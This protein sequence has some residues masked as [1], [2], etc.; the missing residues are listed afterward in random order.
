MNAP[1]LVLPLRWAVACLAVLAATHAAAI[2]FA[3]R[4]V[5]RFESRSG[6]PFGSE[7]SVDCNR[8]MLDDEFSRVDVFPAQRVILIADKTGAPSQKRSVGDVLLHGQARSAAGTQVPVSLRVALAS[9]GGRINV[10]LHAQAPVAGKLSDLRL[11]PYTIS[12]REGGV[13]RVIVTPQQALDAFANPALGPRIGS[14]ALQVQD[15]LAGKPRSKEKD[16]YSADATFGLGA[17][18]PGRPLARMRFELKG[19]ASPQVLPDTLLRGNWTLRVETLT[20]QA[21]MDEVRR[22]LVLTR[23][24]RDPL[25]RPLIEK[26]WPR[27]TKLELGVD[28]NRGFLRVNGREIEYDAAAHSATQFLQDSYPGMVLLWQATRP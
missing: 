7:S 19:D 1:R 8:V 17:A 27:G 15:H 18:A 6:C 11:D 23:L 16:R 14:E 20:S 2:E 26:G 5:H 24:D 3:E 25:V 10:Q 9:E 21:P 28:T 12:V 4:G 22:L 13:A